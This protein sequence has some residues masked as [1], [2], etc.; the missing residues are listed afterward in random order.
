MLFAYF[1]QLDQSL[2]R[3]FTS[4]WRSHFPDFRVLGNA[5]IEP[6][7]SK[8]L[9]PQDLETYRRIR[10]PSA[11]ADV[12]RLV[13]LYEFGGLY[14]DCHCAVNDAAGVQNVLDMLTQYEFI[15]FDL[16]ADKKEPHQAGMIVPMSSILCARP[17]SEIILTIARKAFENLGAQR[18]IER[19]KGFVAYNIATL[20]GP[21]LIADLIAR[22]DPDGK[23]WLQ[24]IYE[25]KIGCVSAADSPIRRY[26]HNTYKYS[27]PHWSKRQNHE[28]LFR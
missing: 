22:P 20:S 6:L 19:D 21:D 1:N 13:A 15:A 11:K 4:N 8:L 26:V 27:A 28:V 12:A 23:S 18:R 2:I 16:E 3:D 14:V 24:P 17:Q 10:I 7:I 5:D 9:T 25:G